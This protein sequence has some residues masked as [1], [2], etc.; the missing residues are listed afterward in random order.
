MKYFTPSDSDPSKKG[1][2]LRAKMQWIHDTLLDTFN[3]DETLWKHDVLPNGPPSGRL[4]VDFST[5]TPGSMTW[6]QGP[7]GNIALAPAGSGSTVHLH[8]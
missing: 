5:Y 2:G 7:G 3:D 4:S 6:N 8:K 1:S